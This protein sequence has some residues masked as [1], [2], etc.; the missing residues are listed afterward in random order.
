MDP[1]HARKYSNIE[2]ELSVSRI[3][4][5]QYPRDITMPVEIDLI[6]ERHERLDHIV[7]AEL[8]E[9]KFGVAAVLI[10]KSG[11]RFDILVDE[12]TFDHQWARAS[13]SIAHEFGHIV[14]HSQV[15]S[16]CTIIEDSLAL[17]RRIKNANAYNFIERNAPYFAGAILIPRRTLPEHAAKVYEALVREFGYDTALIPNKLCSTLATH[18]KVNFQPMEIRLKELGLR[19]KIMSALKVSSPY[20]EP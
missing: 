4:T 16:H 14:L 3:L 15:W 9:D 13:F 8:L 11:G 10:C 2:I 12:G 1:S 6:V 5:Q 17:M 20:I 18:Y 19:T 7:P